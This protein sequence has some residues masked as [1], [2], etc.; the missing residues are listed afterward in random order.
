MSDNIK[1]KV[2]DYIQNNSAEDIYKKIVKNKVSSSNVIQ[3]DFIEIYKGYITEL[4]TDSFEARL[5]NMLDTTDLHKTATF[6]ID[7][8]IGDPKI[9]L[10]S[11]FMWV[12]TVGKQYI[13]FQK[14]GKP[15]PEVYEE[16]SNEAKRLAEGLNLKE[17]TD[18]D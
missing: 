13:K 1:E 3:S 11:V 18:N 2:L 16:I 10:G 15:S 8:V 17:G 9:Q 6:Q 14:G 7:D 5:I 12:V 4:D